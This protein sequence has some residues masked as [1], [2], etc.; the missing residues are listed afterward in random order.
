MG[1]LPLLLMGWPA[2]MALVV[3]LVKNDRLRGILVYGGAGGVMALALCYLGVWLSG[4]GRTV[5]A[6]EFTETADLLMTAAE[7]FVM[8][9]I[10]LLS[11]KYRKYPVML[12]SVG[13]TALLLWSEHAYPVTEGFHI[14]TD[15]LTM[16]MCVLVALV[17][18]FIFIYSVGYMRAYHEH[19]KDVRDRSGFFFAMLFF[20]L[21]AMFG[22]VLSENLVWLY[23]FW[24]LTSVISFLLIGYTRTQEAIHNS[25]RALWMNLLGGAGFVVA[26][27]DA[28]GTL[29]TV[30]LGEVVAAGAAIPVAMMAFAGMT[31]AAQ[32]PFSSWL[33]G[34]MVAPTPSSALLHSATMVK[35]GDYLL[36]RLAPAMAGT[37]T[38]TMV[39][40]LGGFTFIAGS[41]MAIAQSDGKKV[42]AFS[43]ISNLGL[44]VACAG[45]GAEETIWA[46]ILLL[47]YH[48]VSKSLLFQAV[49]AVENSLGSRDVEDMHGLLLR[50]PRLTYL[51]G[52][53][54]AGMYLAP[55]G[56]LISKWVALRA[57]VN[58][59]DVLLVLFIAYGSA[60]TM[61]YWTKWLCKLVSLHHTRHKVTDIT[62]RDQY[63]SM[64]VHGGCVLGMC[65]LFPLLTTYVVNPIIKQLF[66]ISHEILSMSAQTT[67]AVML[68]SVILVP[69]VMFLATRSARRHY[70]P[71]YMSGANEGDNTYFEDSFGEPKHLYLSNWYFKGN[72]GMRRLMVPAEIVSA[73]LLV[74][75]LCLI[76][77]QAV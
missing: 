14:K 62:R 17:G 27:A 30:Q 58:A 1:I 34:A 49:G 33:L 31:K 20:F 57:F 13:Q 19:H 50:M 70:V 77:G 43:T 71:S 32:L 44:I 48:S 66:G 36:I 22:L 38:G 18:G 6:Y 4:G 16:M 15:G 9:L 39:A 75:L 10:V 26:I 64:Y 56:M 21:S 51:L 65:L 28:A 53:G 24:E 7:L 72:F 29:G 41:M 76:V 40:L 12:L 37:M 42:L 3:W 68:V 5:Y 73:G 54:I 25:F 74:V 59:G 55:F 63:L 2:A 45:I 11:F 47:I 61:F 8:A 60:T 67:M 23:F 52:I 69:G 46:A 35:A